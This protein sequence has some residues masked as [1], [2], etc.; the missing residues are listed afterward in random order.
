MGELARAKIMSFHVRS[1]WLLLKIAIGVAI[2]VE[3]QSIDICPKM[4]NYVLPGVSSSTRLTSVFY[5]NY[6][7]QAIMTFT[8]DAL[9][10]KVSLAGLIRQYAI[11]YA[12]HTANNIGNISQMA[13]IGLRLDDDC[14]SL[15]VAMSRGI[16]LVS[17]LR[18]NS[19]CRA[20]FLHCLNDNQVNS[21]DIQVA[22]GIIG[23]SLSFTTIPLAILTSLYQMPHISHSASSSLLSKTD[24]YRSFFRTIPSDIHQVSVML[25]IMEIFEWNLIIAVGSDDDYGKLAIFELETKAKMRNI[26]IV[27]TAYIPFK[28]PNT[29]EH[30]KNLMELIIN[31]P[32]AKVVVLFLYVVDLGD[33]ILKEAKERGVKRI[34]LTS[35]AWC[36]EAENL[37]VTALKNETHGIISVSIKRNELPAFKEYVEHEVKTNFLC[38]MW[39]KNYLKNNFQC[40]PKNI[41]SNK[42]ILLGHDNCSVFVKDVMRK[43]L[44]PFGK[45]TNLID[46]VTALTLSIHKFLEINCVKGKTCS[47]SAI[48]PV[49]LNAI[50]RNISFVN[51]VGEPITFDQSGDPNFIFYSIDNLQF[52]DG[53]LKYVTVGNWTN[54]RSE[55][56]L[57]EKD[58]IKW[59]FWFQRLRNLDHP[60][61]RCSPNCKKGQFFT[62]KIGCCWSCENCTDNSYSNVLMADRCVPCGAGNHTVDH[63]TCV[64]TPVTWLSYKDSEGAAIFIISCVGLFLTISA[65]IILYKLRREVA[66]DEPSPHTITFACVILFLT[67]SSGFLYVFEPTTYLCHVRN[68]VFNLLL[69]EFSSFLLIKTKIT[70]EYLESNFKRFLK[71]G[72]GGLF[73]A[74]MILVAFLLLLQIGS[75]IAWIRIDSEQSSVE[76]QL[77]NSGTQIEKR[78]NGNLTSAR[79]V[80]TFIPLVLL[81]ISTFCAFRER[82]RA[83]VFYEPKFLSFFCVAL[84]IKMVAFISTFK[85]LKG[86]FKILVM[87]FIL[88]V[89]GF[90][91]MAC[92]ILPKVYVSQS[93]FFNVTSF[94]QTFTPSSTTEKEDESNQIGKT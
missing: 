86:N 16:E 14:A 34:W 73:A 80:S 92:F 72:R 19:V 38:N 29:L 93:R 67:F 1:T 58:K 2:G 77:V 68:A 52:F 51:S 90:I 22:T 35:D 48:D 54:N 6:T 36:P 33:L 24:V 8:E 65:A 49:S 13:Q 12:V 40:E 27:E 50:V 89:S 42:E 25:D 91:F 43:I 76:V 59:P 7:I 79:L 57:L 78:C 81:L 83:H 3:M 44:G 37:N 30:V 70:S 64:V 4:K 88:N 20:N 62:A 53:V 5:G 21:D 55:R 17:M 23:A 75:I 41:S 71:G 39:L 87:A 63:M 60:G 9:C 82:N 84:C 69:M 26:C 18:K 28:A 45:V 61:S 11:K 94:M 66:T 56:L 31:T 85:Y 47:I 32:K 10:K 46:A 15:P 74:Q